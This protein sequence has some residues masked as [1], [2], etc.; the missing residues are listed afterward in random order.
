MLMV[1]KTNDASSHSSM[2]SDCFLRYLFETGRHSTA[3]WM[4]DQSISICESA[5][6]TGNHPG[7]SAWYVKDMISHYVNLKAS[8]DRETPSAD[9]GLG[10]S[11]SVLSIR[12]DNLR[13]DV[14]TDHTWVAAAEGNL[15]VSLMAVDRADE[16][17]SILQCLVEREDM[18]P[19][20]GIY[21]RNLYLCLAKLG[22]FEEAL[23]VASSALSVLD[24][25]GTDADLQMAK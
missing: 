21:L 20:E 9:H 18:R 14:P 1:R 6:E 12:R 13:P 11:E 2:R 22:R 8:V 24:R 7:F 4:A 19:N 5:L 25:L 16:A 17:L 10:L 3:V 15:A 23:E